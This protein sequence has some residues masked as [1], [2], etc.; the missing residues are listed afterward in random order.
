[1]KNDPSSLIVKDGN[2]KINEED[3]KLTTDVLRSHDIPV[4]S[5][6]SN[7]G[8]YMNVVP[9][10][11]DGQY[12]AAVN[13]AAEIKKQL[14]RIEVTRYEQ[15][16]PLDS[17]DFIADTLTAEEAQELY[18]AVSLY[19]TDVKFCRTDS[20]TAVFYP[21]EI[22]ETVQRAREEYRASLDESEKYLIDVTNDTVTMDVEKLVM[23]ED[24]NSYF[25]RVPNTAALDYLRL[26]KSEV[27]LT[28]GGKTLSMKLDMDREYYVFD[29]NKML[30]STRKGAELAACY[31]TKHNNVNKD[32]QIYQSGNNFR[33]IDLY[34]A[35]QN[36]LISLGL[37]KASEIK[38]ELLKQGISPKAVRD[39][40]SVV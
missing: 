4:Y 18:K 20:G 12:E 1:M 19:G 30:K 33:R 10:E 39:R 25:V 26:D 3:M 21:K 23:E 38:T 9:R 24:N 16:A 35:E 7:D 29:E 31:N 27:E 17:L 15:T 5:F 11:F 32:T 34:S 36:R 14:G 13:E 40:K 37:N 28:N 8:K 6:K 22:S 2:G